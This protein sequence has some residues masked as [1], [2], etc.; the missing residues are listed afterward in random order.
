MF[1][2]I[3]RRSG[4]SPTRKLGGLTVAAAVHAGAL[5]LA[6]VA[7]RT[8]PLEVIQLPDGPPHVYTP[9]PGPTTTTTLVKP[10][11]GHPPKPGPRPPRPPRNEPKP[12]EVAPPPT[13]TPEVSELPA[14]IAEVTGPIDNSVGTGTPT[15]A[16]LACPEG[17]VCPT[18]G[19]SQPE[20]VIT[21]KQDMERPRPNCEPPAPRSPAEAAQFG[22][23]GT[24]TTLYVVYADGHVGNVRV[25]NADAPPIFARAVRDWLENCTF[26]AARYQGHEV[27]VRMSQ[28]FRFKTR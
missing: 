23:E 18:S 17:Q 24:V 20:E 26:S 11:Q 25:V 4:A 12:V 27:S 22:L 10:P 8:P 9:R 16:G 3:G 1:E 15:G 28:T 14:P 7:T 21:F 5:A 13:P 2:A 6:L 19:S